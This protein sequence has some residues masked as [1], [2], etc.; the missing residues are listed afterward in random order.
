[1]IASTNA[2]EIVASLLF[3]WLALVGLLSLVRSLVWI[4]RGYVSFPR[5]PHCS[6][7]VRVPVGRKVAIEHDCG[8]TVTTESRWRRRVT[9]A[10]A[11][12]LLVRPLVNTAE[13]KGAASLAEP[14]GL[15][16]DPPVG[17][18]SADAQLPPIPA[19][20]MPVPGPPAGWY[21]HPSGG[22]WLHWWDGQRWT[23][24]VR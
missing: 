1:M 19:V 24:H 9:M 18:P 16:A 23:G 11:E 4:R 22:P 6:Q 2:G 13:G 3:L 10:P 14:G 20:P 17:E 8:S 7:R 21:S 15:P 12:W 5:C